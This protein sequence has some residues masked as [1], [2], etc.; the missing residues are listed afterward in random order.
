IASKLAAFFPDLSYPQYRT[1]FALFNQRYSTNTTP[2]WRRV[3]PS[4]M[5]AHNGEINTIHGNAKCVAAR[6]TG[7]RSDALADVDLRTV[8][9]A[10]HS[11]AGMLD[12]A[13]ELLT[14]AGRDVRH[15][16]MM[17]NPEAGEGIVGMDQARRDFYGYHACFTEP[18]D[19]PAAIV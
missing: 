2:A 6:D 11:A 4:S 7:P 18:W 17:L 5:M 14:L 13:V 9:E 1:A 10:G 16:L 3:Q 19:G 15:V 8:L 12:N